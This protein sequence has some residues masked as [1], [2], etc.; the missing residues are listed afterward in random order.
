MPRVDESFETNIP[1]YLQTCR[2]CP[3]P[4]VMSVSMRHGAEWGT[5]E[6]DAGRVLLEAFQHDGDHGHVGVYHLR[7]YWDKQDPKEVTSDE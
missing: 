4:S 7:W 3:H 6:R 2:A 1:K 5:C